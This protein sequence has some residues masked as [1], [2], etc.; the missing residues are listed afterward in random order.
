MSYKDLLIENQLIQERIQIFSGKMSMQILNEQ[1][2]ELWY[3]NLK[4]GKWY[5]VNWLKRFF[6]VH[7]HNPRDLKRKGDSFGTVRNAESTRY[8]SKSDTIAEG[9][10][11]VLA[12]M[13]WKTGRWMPTMDL[14]NFHIKG[15]KKTDM[16]RV[17]Y[18][19]NVSMVAATAGSVG[20]AFREES[21]AR[22]YRIPNLESKDD[23]AL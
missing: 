22:I 4:A 15:Y 8:K 23:K 21:R 5:K 14:H 6:V 2:G 7:I 3:C 12:R 11:E 1:S 10:V 19:P 9:T 17:R 16:F 13:P 20:G 18:Q